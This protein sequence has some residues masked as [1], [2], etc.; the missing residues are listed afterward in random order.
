[1]KTKNRSVVIDKN[2]YGCP[3]ILDNLRT[4]VNENNENPCWKAIDYCGPDPDFVPQIQQTYKTDDV[5]GPLYTAVVCLNKPRRTVAEAL[6]RSQLPISIPR[7]PKLTP[8]VIKCDAV[9]VGSGSGGGVVAGVLAKSGYKVLVLE[10]GNYRARS[11]LSLLEGPSMDEMYLGKGLLATSNMEAV[12]LAGSTVGGGSAVN[13]SA[14]IKTPRHV[15]KEWSKSYELEMFESGLYEEA[16]DVVC[17]R[18]GVQSE[19]VDEGFNNAV[20][21]KG[22]GELGF[23]IENIPRNSPPDHYC[24]WCCLGCKDGRKKDVV[25]GLGGIGNGAILTGCEA[26]KVVHDRKP[27]RD[28]STA[29]G[30]LFE[31]QRQDGSKEVCLVESKVTIVACELCARPGSLNEAG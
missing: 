21:R 31:F 2:R 25:G 9:V 22:C 29:R 12:I 20:L 19:V 24:G 15:R 11:N 14:S 17:E 3:W 30:V 13:W 5:L 6:Q 7:N 1:M 23:P 27:G 8:M 10:K 18:M 16:L 26:V 28:R 4:H